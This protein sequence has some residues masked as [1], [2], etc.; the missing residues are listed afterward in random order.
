MAK[1]KRGFFKLKRVDLFSKLLLKIHKEE[2]ETIRTSE[3][4][5]ILWEHEAV[6][7]IEKEKEAK[8]VG[9]AQ[10]VIQR[11]IF[12][13]WGKNSRFDNNYHLT[14]RAC[15]VKDEL[16]YFGIWS[17]NVIKNKLN[18]VIFTGLKSE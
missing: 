2:S 18:S 11:S 8:V 6:E 13:G 3:E 12:L 14:F 9:N 15:V 4:A 16:R 17:D 10:Y 5:K 1:I 7:A